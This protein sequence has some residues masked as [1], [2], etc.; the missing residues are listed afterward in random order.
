[1]R[2]NLYGYKSLN[3]F[4]E[5]Q[6][7]PAQNFEV[8][9]EWKAYH[10]SA[11]A[12]IDFFP[13]ECRK[14]Q[15]FFDAA[16][17]RSEERTVWLDDIRITEE[18][19]PHPAN[20]VND[21]TIPLP[22]LDHGGLKPGDRLAITI[23]PEKTLGSAVP[24]VGG[25]SFHRVAG[26]SGVP[27]DESGRYTL[28]SGMEAA[29]KEMRLPMTRFYALAD[30]SFPVEGAIDRVAELCG[31]IGVA[32][33]QCVLE[34]ER[35]NAGE[36]VAP[37]VWAR[38]IRYSVQ[39]GYHFHH[40]E[41]S[42]EP[43]S[44]LWGEGKAFPK[45]EVFVDHFKQVS[46]AV[47]EADPQAQIGVDIH[48]TDLRWGNYLLQ[49]LAGDYD[50]VAPHFYCHTPVRQTPFEDI[51]L[52]ENYRLLDRARRISALLQ[53]YNPGR[54]VYQYDTEWGLLSDGANGQG[55]EKE[56]R[57]ANIE[58]ALHR[59]VRLIYYARGKDLRGA[60]SWSMFTEPDEP[61]CA[62]LSQQVPEQRYLLYWL[63]YYFNRHIGET[64]LTT[65]GTAPWHRATQ[66]DDRPALDGPLTP[67][68]ATLSKDEREMYFVVVN[69]SWSRSVPCHVGI[70]HFAPGSVTGIELSQDGP[71]AAPLLKRKEDAVTE[72]PLTLRE[73]AL[74][75]TV[76]A[77]SVLF[78]TLRH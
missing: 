42:N 51:V 45:P 21:A 14:L 67:M 68:L 55:S 7:P 28:L 54:P 5:A 15:F 73:G 23:D 25:V 72:F 36:V 62:I 1:V 59:A 29:V 22:P 46:R 75:F 8:G 18:P 43:Y 40:W 39:Q 60:S 26:F 63:H 6:G 69:G 57:N 20:L 33:E 32:Q 76:P 9:K 58:G 35:Q 27:F 16:D 2:T 64:V 71:D 47:R 56:I 11:R 3:P 48:P 24:A 77:H 17:D 74:D 34:F 13:S 30:E 31:K 61:G 65:A 12:G 53:A 38:G 52:T 78:I 37:E 50:F 66:P 19:D 10:F 41:I 49:A 4:T 70:S 44:S